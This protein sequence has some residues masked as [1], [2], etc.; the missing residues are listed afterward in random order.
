[1]YV[2]MLKKVE[3]RDICALNTKFGISGDLVKQVLIFP[4]YVT[5]N[6]RLLVLLSQCWRLTRARFDPQRLLW[7]R[8]M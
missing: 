1:M 8:R 4:I 6:S 2:F 3:W 5:Q 7:P